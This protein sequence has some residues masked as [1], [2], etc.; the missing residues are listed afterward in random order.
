MGSHSADFSAPGRANT[1]IAS[2]RDASVSRT[3]SVVFT[4]V[5]DAYHHCMY[6]G[7]EYSA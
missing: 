6:T 1:E 3:T 7:Y 4:R 5:F 2:E